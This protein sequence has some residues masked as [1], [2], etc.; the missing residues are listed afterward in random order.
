MNIIHHPPVNVRR[1]K[2]ASKRVDRVALDEVGTE[3]VAAN[4]EVSSLE[5][6][7]KIKIKALK[8]ETN[9]LECWMDRFPYR[10]RDELIEYGNS[11]VNRAF[12]YYNRQFKNENGYLYMLR[13]RAFSCRLFYPLFLKMKEGE[14]EV[15]RN[16]SEDMVHFEY[17]HF[18]DK[19]IEY[20]G[21]GITLAV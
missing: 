2:K 1:Q 10:T 21:G 12:Q 8:Y 17:A 18:D 3:L 15:L 9:N 19:F 6:T 16:L 20:L 5:D 4:D 11:I 13:K 14:I 7:L